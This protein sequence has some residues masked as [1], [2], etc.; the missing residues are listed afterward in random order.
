MR[1]LLAKPAHSLSAETWQW[2]A[3][4]GLLGLIANSM[5]WA[6]WWSPHGPYP[7]WMTI[8]TL[9]LLLPLRGLLHGRRRTAQWASFLPFPYL[10]GSILTVYGFLVPP[11]FTVTAD[12][13]GG[14]LQGV[15]SLLLM[16]GCMYYAYSTAG[17]RKD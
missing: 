11:Y 4:A 12:F 13:A 10:L 16:T 5:A 3:V 8:K 15:L 9:P 14:V 6:L 7:A 1:K 17:M 2:L